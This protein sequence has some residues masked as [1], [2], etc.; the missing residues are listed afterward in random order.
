MKQVKKPEDVPNGKHY[1]VIEF[2]K[3][4][5]SSGWGS[6]NDSQVTCPNY[7][8]TE[9][10]EAWKSHIRELEGKKKSGSYYYAPYVAFEVKS[11]AII[12]IQIK[13]NDE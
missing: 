4:T 1:A 8:V 11:K 12:E 13:V 9:D 2:H 10:I 5:E 7:Y 6:E 3:V